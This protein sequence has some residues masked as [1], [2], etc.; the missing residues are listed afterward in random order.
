MK[1]KKPTLTFDKVLLIY[2]GTRV[3]LLYVVT[4]FNDLQDFKLKM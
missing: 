3:L 1:D 2:V 4:T